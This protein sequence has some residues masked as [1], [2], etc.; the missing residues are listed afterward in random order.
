MPSLR[1][2]IA[3]VLA[4][5]NSPVARDAVLGALATAPRR[6]QI[7]LSQ[8]LAA[9]PPGANA[10][11]E[12]AESKKLSPQVLADRIV[13]ERLAAARI[14]KF[15]ERFELLTKD[16]PSANRELQRLIDKRRADFDPEQA[17]ATRGVV[18][19]E[20]S[21]AVCHQ[22]AG[23]GAVVGPQL[24]GVGTRGLERLIEDVLDSNRNVDPAFRASNI[25]LRDDTAITGLMRHEEGEV[26]VFADTTGKE[27]TVRKSEIVERRESELSLMPSNFGDLLSVEE[28]NDLM[29][30]LLS[31]G[32]K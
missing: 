20:K 6:Q 11:L 25:T 30:F 22:M 17:S 27:I 29:A 14:P 13:K 24:D 10:L 15:S 26:I 3:G 2:K 18:V 12:L 23:K 21:C 7:K 8:S 31:P 4:G 5:L 19:F 16:L 32:A 9:S 1:E 28:F